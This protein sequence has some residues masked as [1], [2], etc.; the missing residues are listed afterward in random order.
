MKIRALKTIFDVTEGRI[1]D[2]VKSNKGISMVSVNVSVL[3]DRK[4]IMVLFN[5]EEFG[6]EFEVVEE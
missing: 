4:E 6:N 2:V 5:D 3:D 1:Y